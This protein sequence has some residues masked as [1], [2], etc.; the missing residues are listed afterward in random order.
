MLLYPEPAPFS[1]GSEDALEGYA[2]PFLETL[3]LALVPGYGLR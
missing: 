2:S 1:E 3:I